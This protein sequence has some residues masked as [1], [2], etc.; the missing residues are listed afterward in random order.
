MNVVVIGRDEIGLVPPK[1]TAIRPATNELYV[2]H[3]VN[4]RPTTLPLAFALWRSIQY[5]HMADNK[6]DI[7]YNWGLWSTRDTIYFLEGRGWGRVGGATFAGGDFR[8]ISCVFLDNLEANHP[9]PSDLAALSQF[10]ATCRYLYGW[11]PVLPHSAAFPTACPG[12]HLR[13]L[14]P[15]F[16]YNPEDPTMP[17]P[18]EI[19]EAVWNYPIDR[20]ADAPPAKAM[21]VEIQQG[22]DALRSQ[23]ITN[24]VQI[25]P[26]TG[27]IRL[28]PQV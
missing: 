2:H 18:A 1:G 17:T 6:S 3:S 20:G 25:P 15:L 10:V 4:A 28:T 5:Q 27:T 21:L 7:A 16:N 14:L 12:T 22:I 19:A 24:G 23:G 9:L 26:L 11:I 13:T 8:S